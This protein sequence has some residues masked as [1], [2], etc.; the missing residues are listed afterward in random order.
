MVEQLVEDY[1]RETSA[2]PFQWSVCDCVMWSAGVLPRLG[3]PHPAPELIGAY[4][5][6]FEARQIIMKRGGFSGLAKSLDEFEEGTTEHGIALAKC[7]GSRMFGLISHGLV[8]LKRDRSV[9][10]PAGHQ[11]LRSWKL[12]HKQ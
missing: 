7:N 5:T 9:W 12:W 8:Y 1:V 3:H 4:D 2:M 10:T 11:I 6:W